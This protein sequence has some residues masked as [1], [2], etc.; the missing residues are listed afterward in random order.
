MIHIYTF[1]FT[2]EI[3]ES[4]KIR[5]NKNLKLMTPEILV[6]HVSSITISK[7]QNASLRKRRFQ[8]RALLQKIVYIGKLPFT[9]HLGSFPDISRLSVT[10]IEKH[11]YPD[12]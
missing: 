11:I 3:S 7:N 5:E 10:I 9:D 8:L 2:C 6:C 12:P 4:D 1:H